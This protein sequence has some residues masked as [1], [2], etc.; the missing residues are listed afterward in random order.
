[1]TAAFT[2]LILLIAV[3]PTLMVVEGSLADG[4]VSAVV[5]IAMVTAG[6][7]LPNGELNRFSRLLRPT[8]FIVL[9]VPCLWMLLQVL[10][11]STRSLANPVWVSASTALGKPFVGAVSLDIGATL[12]SLARYC[13]VLG[14]AFV[15]AIIT[16]NRPRAENVLSLLTGITVLIAAELIGFDLGYLRLL[17]Y[18][19]LAEPAS[20]MNIVALGIVLCCATAI[21]AYE[22]VEKTR[23]SKSRTAAIVAGSGSLVGG[24]ICLSA[25][26]ITGDVILF[27][28][29][30]LGAGTLIAVFAIRRWRLGPLGQAGTAALAA[31][32]M[33]GVFAVVPARKETDSTLALSAQGQMSSTQRM[34]SDAK[35]T[36]SGAGSLEALLPL[37]RDSADTLDVPNTALAIAIEMGRPFLWTSIIV[38]LIGA[39]M[40]FRRALLRGRDYV[41]SAAGAGCIIGLLISSFANDGHF[42]LTAALTISV[43]CGLAFAQSQSAP[44]RDFGGFEKLYSIP[45]NTK[46]PPR[47]MLPQKSFTPTQK[48]LRVAVGLFGLFLAAQA[49][50]ILTPERYRPTHI[51]LPLDAKSAAIA[52]AEQ[53]KI[54]RAASLAIVRGDLWAEAAF[55]YGG[56]LWIDRAMELG[57]NDRSNTEALDPLTRALRYS[58]HRGDV[59]LVFA[60]LADRYKWANYQPS[61]LLKMSYYTAPSELALFPLRLSLSLSVEGLLDEAELAEMVRRDIS[62]VLT[63]APSLRP[64]LV[65]AYRSALPQ[66]KLFAER[67]VAEIDPRYVPV[68]RAAAP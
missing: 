17:G 30:L 12:L 25:I 10:P 29:A 67:A 13:A 61:S 40:L 47:Q 27:V 59:W 57:S 63:R 15:T 58:P 38:L 20:A 11:I 43:V 32:A 64:A 48:W 1:M 34:L 55:T 53:D 51:R 33:I 54:K 39:G 62:V 52:F 16:L 60:A 42:A 3:L 50:W 18:E 26:L 4:L 44:N 22:H 5:A 36:G 8:A 2:V 45:N 37:Y 56:E 35:W 66:S 68:I 7:T 14:A 31:I 21:R 9:F 24:L 65:A 6:L 28:A 49:V 41:Y 19:R 46:D 23:Q